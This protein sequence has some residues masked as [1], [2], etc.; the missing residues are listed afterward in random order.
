MTQRQEGRLLKLFRK[1]N[2]LL[3]HGGTARIVKILNRL[4][5]D[6]VVQKCAQDVFMKN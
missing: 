3:R 5:D 2:S 1:C 6:K 4:G